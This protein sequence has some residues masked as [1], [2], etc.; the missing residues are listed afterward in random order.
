[1]Q[2]GRFHSAIFDR[3]ERKLVGARR[4][5]TELAAHRPR[6]FECATPEHQSLG[7]N[8]PADA[9]LLRIEPGTGSSSSP[10]EV[11]AAPFFSDLQ[12]ATDLPAGPATDFDLR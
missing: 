9:L 2:A 6:L 12:P 4:A 5:A 1:V 3:S 11:V 10:T 8:D 7:E